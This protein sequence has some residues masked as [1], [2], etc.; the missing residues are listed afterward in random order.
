M[1]RHMDH[2]LDY[3][4]EY[5]GGCCAIA[6]MMLTRWLGSLCGNRY[7]NYLV[8]LY[9]GTKVLYMINVVLQLYVLCAFLGIEY[10]WYGLTMLMDL[11]RGSDWVATRA[12][13][14][15]TL[16][17]FSIRQMGTTH[18]HTV[19][20]V[21]PIN[22][23]NE[24]IYIFLWFWMVF[25]FGVTILS[26]ARWI[27]VLMFRYSRVRYIRTHLLIMK[28][29]DTQSDRELR[30]SEAFTENY[31]RQDGIFVLKL[32]AKNSTELVVAD[33]VSALWDNYRQ[34][35]FNL[36]DDEA[37]EITSLNQFST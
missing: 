20:C 14:R 3:Q 24:K 1:I 34:K 23:F 27:W 11:L 5:R 29:L 28:R 2:Y 31:L 10:N 35:P 32:V 33:I 16:C 30:M 7:G 21:L 22:L 18:P 19:Q 6:K 13:P 4:R 36:D 17:D 26:L 25:V 8:L 12:F 9:L 15:L 37:D